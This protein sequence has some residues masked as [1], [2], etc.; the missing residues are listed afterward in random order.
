MIVDLRSLKKSE[1]FSLIEVLVF[2]TLISIVLISAV[3]FTL[4]L[5]HTM[6]YNQHKLYATHYVQDLKEWLDSER[7]IDWNEFQRYAST[8]GSTYC[9]NNTLNPNDRINVLSTG[10]CNFDGVGTLDPQIFRRRIT[11]EKDTSGTANRVTVTFEVGWMEDDVLQTETIT[12]VYSL[13][14]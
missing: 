3:G 2:M 12:S 5:V 4:N 1:A 8:S 10:P 7:E 6:S 9:A 14:Q 11:M 13:W